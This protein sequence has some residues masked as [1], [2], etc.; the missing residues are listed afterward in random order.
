MALEG[1]PLQVGGFY[2]PKG[3]ERTAQAAFATLR[4]ARSLHSVR[5]SESAA[6]KA[7]R[8]RA[9]RPGN[10]PKGNRPESTSSPPRG[11]FSASAFRKDC[12]T[13]AAD[14][15]ALFPKG[16]LRQKATRWHFRNY[17]SLLV[18]KSP[19]TIW[20]ERDC[21]MKYNNSISMRCRPIP[22]S[23][24]LSGRFPLG[25][26]PGLEGPTPQSLRRDRFTRPNRVKAADA[27]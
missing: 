6:T 24:A 22:C 9:F 21:A 12:L 13:R 25:T 7:L 11:R 1:R 16:N 19:G 18:Q 20:R 14:F 5:P 15:G 3:E 17:E 23:D 27:P 10:V 26:F 8:S 4:R 2:R